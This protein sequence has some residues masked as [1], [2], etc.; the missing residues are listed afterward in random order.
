MLLFGDMSQAVTFGSRR[1]IRFRVDESRYAEYDQLVL[2]ATQRFYIVAHDL[3]TDSAL[4]FS[5]RLP[6]WRVL[7]LKCGCR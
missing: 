6:G 4:E 5:Q 2:I 1:D 7:S 3:G